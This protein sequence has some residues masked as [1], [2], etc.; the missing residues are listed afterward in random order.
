M[1]KNHK[2]GRKWTAGILTL[3]MVIGTLSPGSAI[4]GQNVYANSQED[5]SGSALGG[6]DSDVIEDKNYM[7]DEEY[8]GF[9][10]SLT[11][12]DEFTKDSTEDNP[13]ND[14]QPT[15]LSELYI[16][17]MNRDYESPLKDDKDYHGRFTVA[18]NVS[19]VSTGA[20]NL[21][22]MANHAVV[23]TQEYDVDSDD[24]KTQ[25]INAIAITPGKMS[26]ADAGV[27]KQLIIEDRLYYDNDS[28]D[29]RQRIRAFAVSD[30]NQYIKG[31]ATDI[32]LTSDN[33][34]VGDIT[35]REQGGLTSMAVGDYDADGYEEVAVHIPSD[36]GGR[37]QLYQ[38]I[39]QSNGSYN[40][41]ADGSF[42]LGGIGNRIKWSDGKCRPLVNLQT[43]DMSGRDD[44]VVNVS[45]PYDNYSKACDAGGMAVVRFDGGSAT[46]LFLDPMVIGKEASRFKLQSAINADLDGDG[47]DEIVVAGYKNYGYENGKNRG[48]IDTSVM[49]LNVLR[50]TNGSY[51]FEWSDDQVKE[52]A[53]HPVIH[54][55][56]SSGDGA[57]ENS[58]IAMT[59]GRYNV[60]AITDT[61][62][63]NGVFLH[64]TQGTADGDDLIKNGYFTRNSNEDLE[65]SNDDEA[66]IG[67]CATACF[68]EN[69]RFAD[70]TVVMTGYNSTGDDT[71]RIDISWFYYG[72]KKDDKTGQTVSMILHSMTNKNYFDD[73]PDEDDN[74]T[75][76]VLAPVNVDRDST[77][78][79]YVGK[80]TGWSKP[81]VYCV[82]LSPPY[83]EELNYSRGTSSFSVNYSTS[84]ADQHSSASG[85]YLG[86]N[87][88]ATFGTASNCGIIGLDIA[89]TQY[90][91]STYQDS[92][93]KGSSLTISTSGVQDY[94]VLFAVPTV[95]YRYSVFLPAHTAKQED[96]DTGAAEKVGDWV[97]ESTGTMETGVD[98]DPV[99]SEMPLSDYNRMAKEYNSKITESSEKMLEIDPEVLYPERTIGDPSSY[100]SS[101]S[102][103][104]GYAVNAYS[105]S[106]GSLFQVPL[107]VKG[108][109]TMTTSLTES[110]TH[111]DSDGDRYD[112][113]IGAT[114]GGRGGFIL[115]GTLQVTGSAGFTG[116][117]SNT[118]TTTDT[119][120][121][122]YSSTLSSLPKE[123][124]TG[125]DASGIPV[126][127][128]T[129]SAKMV[130]WEPASLHDEDICD[131]EVKIDGT[132]YLRNSIPV[133]GYI[134]QGAE[135]APAKLPSD[136]KVAATG[137]NT[138]LLTWNKP[139]ES[140]SRLTAKSYRLFV[141]TSADG[142]YTAVTDKDNNPVLLSADA[143]SYLVQGLSAGKTYFFRMQSFTDAA[144]TA[145]GSVRG[146]YAQGTTK[147]GS[148][149]EPVIVTPPADCY[150]NI[151]QKGE[152][153]IE[154]TPAQAQDTLTYQWQKLTDTGYGASW[155]NIEDAA[156]SNSTTF[157]AAYYLTDG[158]ITDTQAEYLDG[159]LYRCAVTEKVSGSQTATTIYSKAAALY[160]GSGK[161]EISLG[162]D[163]SSDSISALDQKLTAIEGNT[164][165]FEASAVTGTGTAA[166][167]VA[168]ETLNLTIAKADEVSENE[169]KAT[170]LVGTY[171]VTTDSK[172]DAVYETS[173]LP[174]G[175]YIAAAWHPQTA[176]YRRAYSDT[177]LLKVVSSHT[178][179]YELNGGSNSSA[180][181]AS[182]TSET[183]SITLEDAEKAG[184]SFT[185]W[186]TDKALTQDVTDNL[187]DTSQYDSDITLYAGWKADTY[188]ISYELNGGDN[189]PD[190]HPSYTTEDT[191]TLAEAT[192]KGY[193]F[194]GWY[195]D[196]SFTEPASSSVSGLTG[197]RT[198]YAKW[199]IE[200]YTI[201]YMLNGGS[202]ASQNPESYTVE[203]EFDFTDPSRES[204]RFTGWYSD[205]E[206]TL[207]VA[208][209]P[210]GSTGDVTVYAGW[211]DDSKVIEISSL[212]E[213]RTA[214]EK[215]ESGE[216]QNA[217]LVLTDN[218]Y[219]Q[220][221]DWELPI[222]TEAMPFEGTFNGNN[223]YICNLNIKC[224]AEQ[225]IFGVIGYSGKVRNVKTLALYSDG[226]GTTVGGIA[227]VNQGT[228]EKCNSGLFLP[229][230]YWITDKAEELEKL[231]N[232]LKSKNLAG[233]I[234]GLNMGRIEDSSSASTVTAASEAGGLTAENS[235]DILNGYN[236]GAV[237]VSSSTGKSGGIAAQNLENGRIFNLYSAGNVSG[238]YSGAIAGTSVGTEIY[239]CYYSGTQSA[240]SNQKL[241]DVINMTGS[242]MRQ[243]DFL[244]VLNGNVQSYNSGSSERNSMLLALE[245]SGSD[246]TVLNGWE[247]NSMR[248]GGFPKV[249]DNDLAA[250]SLQDS[251]SHIALTGQR[252]HK[253][254][255]LVVN[256]SDTS[257][258]AYKALVKAADGKKILWSGSN[259]LMFSNDLSAPYDGKLV[260]TM[261]TGTNTPAASLK[262]V[263][264]TDSGDVVT[265]NNESTEAGVF[266]GTLDTL[267]AMALVDTSAAS[268]AADSGS[269]STQTRTVIKAQSNVRAGDESNPVLLILLM[270]AAGAVILTVGCFRYRKKRIA[271][272][273]Y[274][275]VPAGPEKGRGK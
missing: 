270:C 197:D 151:R 150:T 131:L 16:G 81:S 5:A 141:S 173:A 172:G 237:T 192:R 96:V 50:Y 109:A 181:P 48:K 26:D 38:P 108:G 145:N 254:A 203:D 46:K 216:Y 161:S 193:I 113:K 246:D 169:Y 9:G 269:T 23:S 261:R 264:Y 240:C 215:V 102:N 140:I 12:P 255:M 241:D 160:I 265:V 222:G 239:K 14:Y 251:A 250:V 225:G 227:A 275:T 32:C 243:E 195:L 118:V 186:Y 45:L 136:L 110:A 158:L 196:A 22:N 82:L 130:K 52:V 142:T 29:S 10:F 20:L 232:K 41:Q 260:W 6:S 37:I 93:V 224:G 163:A 84:K 15:I 164:V 49:L 99:K 209:I 185:G 155:T 92:V 212:D 191:W 125:T 98:L 180:N 51:S 11:D 157:N 129:Y 208:S 257:S 39:E 248:N 61:V 103:I 182:F 69:E 40:L 259:S 106:E 7:S 205:A 271:A 220:G 198:F 65:F 55:D 175:N 183:G 177:V 226:E 219:G 85:G 76:M 100:K 217:S 47:K 138:A 64:F 120:G 34:W 233:G 53:R 178:I 273:V 206:L 78:T 79:Q 56:D 88:L 36:D 86:L 214:A 235:G 174:E 184:Y 27:R 176:S 4:G 127:A 77:Y 221:G 73:N 179:L 57:S 139:A 274:K 258:D 207:G 83:W 143:K 126:S 31:K 211:Q 132:T 80:S 21:D 149:I 91:L 262:L 95:K 213:L 63:C 228:I 97:N 200:N 230:A 266:K 166:Q 256:A 44:L 116:S 268:A 244:T 66:F 204:F 252:I 189:S 101:T 128:Y 115:G 42:Y 112:F 8:K 144:G 245:S 2:T 168:D 137:R 114:G 122:S 187:L 148:D 94:V 13:L 33:D 30:S 236:L 24:M 223:Y 124:A 153:T 72:Q 25:C 67:R 111:S 43:T 171:P 117:W 249:L 60:S 146:P 165:S 253:S 71:C 107:D 202:N 147:S 87:A 190:N 154:A 18:E 156:A 17:S 238:G 231:N 135:K 188:S 133:I 75:T 121:D 74:G 170:E 152:F 62:F 123:A 201:H 59:A 242:A 19:A 89:Y 218:I 263:Q 159:T 167:A 54:V 162:L 210:K 234:A 229:N 70:Q 194:S 119:Q 134:V 272:A 199:E 90:R 267:S 28:D 247:V 1:L 3:L 58:P 104:T 105:S 68:S 35:I